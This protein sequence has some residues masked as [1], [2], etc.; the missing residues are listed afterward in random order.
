MY[1]IKNDSTDQTMSSKKTE[2]QKFVMVPRYIKK[3][4][5][6]RQCGQFSEI[7]FPLTTF[8]NLCF[9][10]RHFVTCP[11]ILNSIYI[12]FISPFLSQNDLASILSGNACPQDYKT[13][14]IICVASVLGVLQDTT[15]FIKGFGKI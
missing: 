9:L 12:F 8:L 10:G 11:V 1:W 5:I 13:I 4:V 7:P 14:T 3:N 6:V 15:F 2:I